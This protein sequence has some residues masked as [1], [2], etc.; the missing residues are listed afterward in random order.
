MNVNTA[1]NDIDLL[2]SNGYT[3]YKIIERNKNNVKT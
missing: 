3:F 2:L 1:I